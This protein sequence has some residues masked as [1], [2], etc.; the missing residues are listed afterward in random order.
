MKWKIISTE[1]ENIEGLTPGCTTVLP[2]CPYFD[3]IF[4]VQRDR[5][6]KAIKFHV[7]YPAYFMQFQLKSQKL[8]PNTD[9][10]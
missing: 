7:N 10:A 6:K 3:S 8:N 5:N 2:K 4:Q 9:P 1:I